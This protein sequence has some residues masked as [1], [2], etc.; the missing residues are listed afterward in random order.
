MTDRKTGCACLAYT[1]L[2]GLEIIRKGGRRHPTVL[3]LSL[4][5]FLSFSFTTQISL[6]C[7]CVLAAG[8]PSFLGPLACVCLRTRTRLDYQVGGYSSIG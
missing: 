6:T 2:T 3:S 4:V 1:E 7:E 5:S 8:I